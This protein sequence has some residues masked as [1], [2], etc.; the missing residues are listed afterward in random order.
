MNHTSLGDVDP[1]RSPTSFVCQRQKGLTRWLESHRQRVRGHG[2]LRRRDQTEQF[3]LF[4][5]STFSISPEPAFP[6]PNMPVLFLGV[7]GLP[8]QVRTDPKRLL[9][10]ATRSSPVPSAKKT[11]G[12]STHSALTDFTKGFWGNLTLKLPCTWCIII[13]GCSEPERSHT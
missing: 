12:T 5:L 1:S 3:F 11:V 10:G 7:V 6:A 4:L 2:R 13:F 8:C 9:W